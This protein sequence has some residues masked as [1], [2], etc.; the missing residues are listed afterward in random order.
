[1][2]VLSYF[3]GLLRWTIPGPASSYSCFEHHRFW[4]VDKEARQPSQSYYYRVEESV[5]SQRIEPPIQTEYLRSGGATIFTFMLAARSPVSS[6]CMRS[7]MPG[8]IVV[9][10]DKTIFPA[11]SRRTSRSH[12]MIEL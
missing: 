5:H 12:F 6:F 4:K 1:M 3:T 2:R 8:Y 9:P 10:P 7:A 11:R